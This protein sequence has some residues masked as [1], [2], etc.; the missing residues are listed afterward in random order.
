[1][2]INFGGRMKSEEIK[3]LREGGFQGSESGGKEV[4]ECW[5]QFGG[6]GGKEI[7]EEKHWGD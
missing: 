6:K 4:Q 5:L 3:S 2:K 1:M 7:G